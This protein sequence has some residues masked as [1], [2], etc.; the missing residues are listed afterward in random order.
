MR[1]GVPGLCEGTYR[2][3]PAVGLI[4]PRLNRK[5]LSF[6]VAYPYVFQIPF[7]TPIMRMLKFRVCW[8]LASLVLWQ[9]MARAEV[10]YSKEEAFELA[11]GVGA[12]IENLPV[13]LTDEQQAAIE[14]LA[15]VKVDSQ[16][17]TF[18]EGRRNGQL[19][20]YAAIESHKVR[21]QP[22]TMLIVLSP[23]G[24]L[25]RS[26]ILAFHEPPEY[27]PPTTWFG[28]L[29]HKPI[30]ELRLD[31]GVDGISGA[32]LSVRASLDGIR[33]AMAV[34]QIAVAGAAN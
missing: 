13:F 25:A 30:A 11:F 5:L 24:E 19:L 2:A 14:K 3:L 8:L 10:F 4:R 28:T 27:K 34:Y 33:K 20:G 15:R 26:E 23:K 6:T 22:E 9:G 12:Q 17:Y 7:P 16:L 21:T 1:A 18:Y 31:Q 32:T 29:L